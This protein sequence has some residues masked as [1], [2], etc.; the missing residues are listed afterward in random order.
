MNLYGNLDAEKAMA[1]MLYGANPKTIVSVVGKEKI[2]F[3]KGVFLNGARNAVLNG[4]HNNKATVDLSAYTTASKDIVLEIN[5][6]SISATTSGTIATD[7]AAIV[8]DIA[9]DVEG[10]TATAGTSGDAGKIFLV[11]D[12]ESELDVKLTYDGSDATASKVT[13]T[14][15]AV[16]AGVSVFH[17]NAFIASRGC[18]VPQEAVA[19]MEKGYIWVELASGVTPDIEANAYVTAAGTFTTESSGNTLVGKFKSAKEAGSNSDELA[20]VSLD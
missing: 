4:K 18:Y 11:S 16:Y 13:E 20:L 12:D 5:G 6:V 2:N 14:S 9:D 8:A 15:D 3:G 7:V 1:G 17:Q 19:V 10:V